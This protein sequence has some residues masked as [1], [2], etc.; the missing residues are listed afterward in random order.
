MHGLHVISG[1]NYIYRIDQADD[2][3]LA[4][5]ENKNNLN[6]TKKKKKGFKYKLNIA[7]LGFHAPFAKKLEVQR[8]ISSTFPY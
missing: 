1:F 8:N 4:R 2:P 5:N 7:S 6:Y 3:A